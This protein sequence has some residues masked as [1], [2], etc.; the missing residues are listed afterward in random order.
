MAAKPPGPAPWAELGTSKVILSV[1]AEVV[2][3][4]DDPTP[5]LKY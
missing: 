1:P 2:R 3:Q 4:I 5:L